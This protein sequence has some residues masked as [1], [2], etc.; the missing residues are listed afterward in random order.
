MS[1]FTGQ[2]TSEV[3]EVVQENNILVTNTPFK[4]GKVQLTKRFLAKK[5]NGSYSDQISEELQSGTTLAHVDVKFGLSILKPL[6]AGWV[7]DFYN[8]ITAGGK[9]ADIYDAI[10]LG[11]GK[12]QAMDS[13][14]DI[15][16]LVNESNIPIPTN[17]EA[18]CQLN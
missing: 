10:C 13:Y 3:K 5:F 11:I 14:H 16:P 6:N 8:F 7:V 2:M 4:Y 18:V 9:S 15:N 17:L 1:V 12:L